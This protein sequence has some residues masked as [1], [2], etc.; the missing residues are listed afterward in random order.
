[1]DLMNGGSGIEQKGLELRREGLCNFKMF[2]VVVE[3][4][5]LGS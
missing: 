1:M 3:I 4:E 5:E 2:L